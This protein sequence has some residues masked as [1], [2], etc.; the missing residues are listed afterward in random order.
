MANRF[1]ILKGKLPKRPVGDGIAQDILEEVRSK[2]HSAKGQT[3]SIKG[4]NGFQVCIPVR[5][6]KFHQHVH[7]S[8]YEFHLEMPLNIG[9]ELAADILQK[10]PQAEVSQSG[11][12]VSRP[13]TLDRSMDNQ[14]NYNGLFS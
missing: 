14:G 2:Q 3:L 6:V 9:R 13:R 12:P 11:L 10:N 5:N 8:H 1:D 7:N 4:P